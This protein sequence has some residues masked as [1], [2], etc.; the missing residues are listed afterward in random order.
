MHESPSKG[1]QNG[2]YMGLAGMHIDVNII[3][4]QR[5]DVGSRGL[6]NIVTH[7]RRCL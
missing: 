1:R 4:F 7:T 3:A 5:I 6:E 2:S